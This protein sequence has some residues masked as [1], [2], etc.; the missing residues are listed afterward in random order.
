MSLLF[1][2]S[3][4]AALHGNSH[5]IIHVE[6]PASECSIPIRQE[7][8][9]A[10]SPGR[11]TFGGFI[12]SKG[13]ILEFEDYK[14]AYQSLF[15]RLD[16]ESLIVSL[17]PEY[18]RLDIFEPQRALM[19]RGSTLYVDCN[20]HI[21]LSNWTEQSLGKGER[22]KLRQA[23]EAGFTFVDVLDKSSLNLCIQL[24]IESRTR[25]GVKLSM[26]SGDIIK[27]IEVLPEIY[28]MVAVYQDENIAAAALLVRLDDSV[29]YVLYWGDSL[30]FRNFSPT[31]FLCTKIIEG[32]RL[33]GVFFLDLGISSLRGE[34]NPGLTRFKANL[35]AT[36]TDKACFL[37]HRSTLL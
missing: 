9:K 28:R 23:R 37:V 32:L 19:V 7:G 1:W 26:S 31:V 16:C 20:F 21:E 34:E 11:G 14:K 4:Y 6:M 8:K 10:Y 25:L 30:E 29:E 3:Q 22:K 18:F 35:G 13:S 2:T 27:A 36:K 17:P 15:E 5:Q 12:P 33:D 24:L